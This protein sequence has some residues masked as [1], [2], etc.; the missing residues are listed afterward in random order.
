M[1]NIQRNEQLARMGIGALLIGIGLGRS[2][3]LTM[4]GIITVITA[5]AKFCPAKKLINDYQ[6]S[7]S[8]RN[9]SRSEM[10]KMPVGDTEDSGGY[11]TGNPVNGVQGSEYES[12][13]YANER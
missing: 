9:L 5:L 12:N 4:A 7:A 3:A 6:E 2:K 10:G 13:A 1:I 11:R 8:G